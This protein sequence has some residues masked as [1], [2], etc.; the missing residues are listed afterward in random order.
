M[1]SNRINAVRK[2]MKSVSDTKRNQ[3]KQREETKKNDAFFDAYALL[4]RILQSIKIGKEKA[5]F[6]VSDAMV[7]EIRE[8]LEEVKQIF[9]KESVS[10]P[11]KISQRINELYSRL[12]FEW[13]ECAK[14]KLGIRS[15]IELM[16]LIS[17]NKNISGIIIELGAITEWP[18]TEK[19]VERYSKAYERAVQI[20][21]DYNFN[22]EVR[23]F[24][25]KVQ[26]K[27]A[28]FRDLTEE[29]R[30]WIIEEHLEDKIGLSII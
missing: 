26:N 19:S 3:Y 11:Y 10:N 22:D 13:E 8:I 29:V 6:N 9:E 17:D 25:R 7:I 28:T 30:N 2:T 12:K 20:I 5:D 15:N 24:L 21:K 23:E 16:K 18:I 27:S 4:V 14:K 1:I